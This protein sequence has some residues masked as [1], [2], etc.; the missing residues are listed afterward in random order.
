LRLGLAGGPL[1]VAIVLARVGHL[2]PL[3]WF[4]PPSANHVLRDIGIVLFLGVVGLS[5]G[6][7]FVEALLYGDGLLWIACGAVITLVP[8]AAVGLY[9]TAIRRMNHLTVCGLLAGSMTDP[10][11]L[12]FANGLAD[13]EAASLAYATVY[14]LVMV[15]RILS[16]QLLLLVLWAG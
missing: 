12:A 15:L 2:G 9:A 16:P 10:P 14:P 8:L 13:S 3:V 11:A 7:G 4:L 1:V 6:R 5:A